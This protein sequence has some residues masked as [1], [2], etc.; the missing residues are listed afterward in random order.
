MSYTGGKVSMVFIVVFFVLLTTGFSQAQNTRP[1]I[2]LLG[3][4]EFAYVP[5]GQT[6]KGPPATSQFVKV[7]VTGDQSK[8][9][10]Y[11]NVDWGG[12]Q[13]H[14]VDYV[15]YQKDVF[16]PAEE[17]TGK[18]VFICFDSVAYTTELWVNGVYIGENLDGTLPFEFDITEA[19][20][21]DDYNT[22]T[23]LVG[24]GRV[25]KQKGA[26]VG[27]MYQWH[28]G[29]WQP[30]RLEGRS[31]THIEN[32]FIK[33]SVRNQLLEVEVTLNRSPSVGHVFQVRVLEEDRIVTEKIV[34]A[35]KGRLTFELQA[36]DLKLWWPHD[37]QLYHLEVTLTRAGQTEDAVTERFGYREVWME[38]PDL[39]LNHKKVRLFGIWGHTGDFY[40]ARGHVQ[41]LNI[42]RIISLPPANLWQQLKQMNMNVVRLHAQPFRQEFVRTA[43]EQ[44]FLII[45]ESAL[46]S[47][48]APRSEQAYEHL[49]RL[50]K[51]FRN[52]PSVI[53][54]SLT[55]EV[56]HQTVPRDPETT[57]FL[58]SLTR[59]VQKLDPTRPS[60][61]SGYGQTQDDVIIN[62][63]YP[64]RVSTQ[65]WP[66]IL[67]WPE[68][69]KTTPNPTVGEHLQWDKQR[70]L[71]VGEHYLFSEDHRVPFVSA[72]MGQKY[73]TL[74]GE[75]LEKK[76]EEYWGYWYGKASLIYRMQNLLS[77]Q[78]QLGRQIVG[79]TRQQ[80]VR[81]I[82]FA[83]VGFMLYPWVRHWYDGERISYEFWLI[84][85]SLEDFTGDAFISVSAGNQLLGEVSLKLAVP[86]GKSLSVPVEL[87]L[88]EQ[89]LEVIQEAVL[90]TKLVG[91]AGDQTINDSRERE[92]LIFPKS[93]TL[94]T[95]N[96]KVYIFALEGQEILLKYIKDSRILTESEE[97]NELSPRE[98]I[99]IVG[100][101][102]PSQLQREIGSQVQDFV[103]AGGTVL[104]LE[105][106]EWVEAL[107]PL[108]IL[109]GTENVPEAYTG[110]STNMLYPGATGHPITKGMPDGAL[111]FWRPEHQVVEKSFILP[112]SANY[113]I[114]DGFPVIGMV[115]VPYG[116]GTYI[117]SQIK[118]QE[119][120]GEEPMAEEM[121]K[122]ILVYLDFFNGHEF[123][124]TGLIA[125]KDSVFTIA[126]HDLRVQFSTAPEET[127][128]RKESLEQIVVHLP[129]VDVDSTLKELVQWVEKGGR[130]ILHGVTSENVDTVNRYFDLGLKLVQQPPRVQLLDTYF[131]WGFSPYL[132]A[133]GSDT[134][135]RSYGVLTM[136]VPVEAGSVPLLWGKVSYG[137]G[138]LVFSQV[139]WEDAT[140]EVFKVAQFAATFFT[141]FGIPMGR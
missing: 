128:A 44:G 33:P 75:E 116:K 72:L 6:P 61:H 84:N 68:E 42:T 32:V 130:L 57:A 78:T 92:L 29:I 9:T 94:G 109:L 107:A 129:T 69:P 119:S 105:Q 117:L 136:D 66:N 43:D 100:A 132:L 122:R 52:H 101:K 56:G 118:I 71:M 14:D 140:D 98:S 54:W 138:E 90:S 112:N 131:N 81:D 79:G 11:G 139:R 103:A 137:K 13:P 120:L 37:P 77:W 115:E 126:C 21:L 70:A 114:L 73:F 86:Q 121:L 5:I 95:V 62:V 123:K 51:T 2:S 28:G 40:N 108:R 104:V 64:E 41:F 31:S 25:A 134:W 91:K 7:N 20:K 99:L 141:N 67:F 10:S 124:A 102:L 88:R 97:I 38:G 93:R 24:S 58:A 113:R 16:I 106:E 49:R 45:V 46:Y 30:A 133:F 85:D 83:P 60:Y 4:W 80:L 53:I 8:W 18:R 110:I 87:V 1:T 50:V 39:I 59:E 23:M 48:D 111:R 65:N 12:I 135:P 27:A 89:Q 34:P 15:W 74:F 47:D 55:N 96:R 36:R 125:G 82:G 127:L 63:H 26:P 17:F 22:I 3:E 19:V 76:E 35:N